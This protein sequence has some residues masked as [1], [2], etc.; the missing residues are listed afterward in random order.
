M[1]KLTL[2]LVSCL[3]IMS[4]MTISPALPGMSD[5]LNIDGEY[6]LII[7]LILTIPALF[8]SIFSPIA[9]RLIDR[10]GRLNFLYVALVVYGIAGM[11]GF[12]LESLNGILISRGLLG[13]AV[14]MSMTIV[15]TLVGDYY[16]GLERQ[17][18]IGLQIAF[19]SLG[20]ILFISGGGALADISWRHPFL[21]YGLAFI[22]LPLSIAFLKEPNLSD[23]SEASDENLK[24]PNYIWY[25]FFNTMI[26]WI[27]FFLI[28]VQLP[29][30]MKEIGIESNSLIGAAIALSTASSAV[31]SISFSRIKGRFNF[32]TIF[33][34]GYILMALGYFTISMA[35]SIGLMMVAMLISGLGIGLM[36]PN[37]NLW[38]MKIAPPK[39]RG[40]E[41][42]KL[43]MF[44]FFG[45]FISPIILLPITMTYDLPS[46]FAIMAFLMA[47]L[48][49]MAFI[50][51]KLPAV[52]KVL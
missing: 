12:Y 52:I 3:T 10:Y 49:L 9:G 33:A 32:L 38:V 35:D 27:I 7:R 2:L 41:I 14:G 18:F 4:I 24:S 34:V 40:K 16:E 30:L 31:S 28:P 42:G 13:V 48:G 51:S 26:M 6:D 23:A 11:A 45:Q 15:V 37:T 46:T 39:I 43:T 44:W 50:L 20:G 21:L 36:I 47:G 1:V 25:L 17:K 22:F 5:E 19:M 29:F 8:I